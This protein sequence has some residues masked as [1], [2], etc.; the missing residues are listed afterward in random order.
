MSIKDERKMEEF[1]YN[2]YT[3]SMKK[4]RDGIITKRTYKRRV[5]V[6]R[7]RNQEI[8]IPNLRIKLGYKLHY[9]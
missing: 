1:Q 9:F 8:C 7:G 5:E 4:M 3:N 6:E 2:K